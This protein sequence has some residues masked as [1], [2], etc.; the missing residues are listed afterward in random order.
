MELILEIDL[1]VSGGSDYAAPER[2]QGKLEIY[3]QEAQQL[4]WLNSKTV[5][6]FPEYLGTWLVV[7]G[8]KQEVY[9]SASVGQAMKIMALSNPYAFFRSFQEASGQDRLK[10]GMFRMK[11]ELMAQ[12]Y[13][14]VF[15]E[16]AS[17]YQVTIV[18]GSMVLPSPQVQ[19]GK[20]LIGTGPLYNVAPVYMP[21][22]QVSS[23]LV[24]K[25]FPTE[26]EQGFINAGQVSDLPVIDTPAGKIGILICADAWFPEAYE[27]M[28]NKGASA[29]VVPSYITGD[30]ALERI[31]QGYSGFDNP[32]DVME[33]DIGIITKKEAWMK[34]T[35]PGR[36]PLSGIKYGVQACLRGQLWDL[37]SDGSTIVV[38]EDKTTAVSNVDGAA[39]VNV[40]L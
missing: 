33:S 32:A 36:L 1:G 3:L 8:E 12:T 17:K 25:T 20:L 27:V 6:I 35:L 10:D 2:F 21:D 5:V 34:Y 23:N 18:A 29:V 38:E 7:A 9:T 37:G 13:N 4:G 19:E 22:G 26:D 15:S 40:W 31:W 16:L 28:S 14:T 30:R 39:M 11:G 24:F